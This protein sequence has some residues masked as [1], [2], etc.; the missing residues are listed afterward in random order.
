[1]PIKKIADIEVSGK[2]LI[3]R[4]DFNISFLDGKILDD[5]RIRSEIEPILKLIARGAKI[6]MIAH[7][8]RPEGKF[9]EK[10]SLKRVAEYFSG[11]INKKIIFDRIEN[12][13]LPKKISQMSSGDIIFL[14]N[15][16]FYPGE[17]KN[18]DE[19]AKKLASLG[20]IYVNDAFAVSH[21]AHASVEAITR[22]IPSY[23]G[24]LF[25][26]EVSVLS[27]IM[28]NPPRPLVVIIGG[29]K[30]STKIK[31]IDIFLKEKKCDHVLVGGALANNILMALGIGVGRSLIEKD[32]IGDVKKLDITSN[33]LHIPCDVVVSTRPNRD[34]AVL[35]GVGNVGEEEAIYDIGP[36]TIGIF[37]NI[38]KKSKMVIWNGPMGYF[39][40]REFATGTEE[41]AKFV[42]E[43]G[44]YSV[45]GGGET[46]SVLDYMKL[47]DKIQHI[48]TA[49]GAMME[50]L[51]GE[52]MPGVKA[53]EK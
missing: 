30:I 20:D 14:E 17:E 29:S 1:M 32:M 50:Y 23:A 31:L 3:V 41:V 40:K 13:E 16:R 8:G 44:A 48:S 46:V 18:D 10:Y 5:F 53:L 47:L 36:D 9:E 49:G 6:I 27:R 12:S 4:V 21:R 22:F 25:E 42:A 37:E 33:K 7:L 28:Q 2:T 11:L 15:L 19:F 24:D 45:I 38:I 39:E 52:E 26:K 35:R 43:S 34:D 51:A